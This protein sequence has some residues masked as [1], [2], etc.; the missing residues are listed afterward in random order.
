M[1]EAVGFVMGS[2]VLAMATV[3]VAAHYYR[4]QMRRKL[5]RRLDHHRDWWDWGSVP[6]RKECG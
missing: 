5:L 4:E 6:V 1:S 3:F 2:F